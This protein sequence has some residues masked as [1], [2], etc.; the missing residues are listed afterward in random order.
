V[1][2]SRDITALTPETIKVY[3]A[4]RQGLVLL[5]VSLYALVTSAQLMSPDLR[6]KAEKEHARSAWDPNFWRRAY[7]LFASC[8]W[9]WWCC[10][11]CCCCVV[12]IVP[13]RTDRD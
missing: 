8:T 6:T 1:G 5:V 10:C 3:K 4:G 2:D 13:E 12:V 7:F 11:C 9:W